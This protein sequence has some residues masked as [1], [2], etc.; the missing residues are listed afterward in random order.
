M[1]FL[2]NL[3]M[4]LV[5]CAAL[6]VISYR[7]KLLTVSGSVA[8][9]AIG[10][11]IGL[12][13]SI[14]WLIV[15]IAFAL[16]GFAVTRYRLELKTRK[17]L[18]EGKKGERT[19]RNVLANGLIPACVA[20]L[21]WTFS[22]QNGTA[23]SLVYLTAV[24]VAASDTIAS[25]LGVLS[26]RTRLITSFQPVATGTDGGVSTYGTAWAFVGALVAS[27]VGWLVIL[28]SH[29]MNFTVLVPVIF[30]FIGCNVDSVIG[31]TL[32]RRGYVDKLGTNISSMAIATVAAFLVV[33][34][35]G[36]G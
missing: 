8:S 22:A 31:A 19:Y 1:S 2:E 14:N 7:L 34:W 11:V 21:A 12:F 26:S 25:E 16:M 10:M 35:L 13:G 9:F 28:N 6:S 18:Q 17:G 29:P 3:L 24:S 36:I 33:F 5:L 20:V 30:G 15:L 23:A 4:V 32:E 27:L